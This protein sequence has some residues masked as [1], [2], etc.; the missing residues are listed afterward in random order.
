M[1]AS[2]AHQARL[3]AMLR[4]GLEERGAVLYGAH[5][6]SRTSTLLFD[7]P[8]PYS[9]QNPV[10]LETE[11][12]DLPSGAGKAWLYVEPDGDVLPAQGMADRVLGNALTDDWQAFLPH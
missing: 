6:A 1:A 3:A 5:A 2:E 10:A 7:L 12:D 9:A 4:R 11:E 8:V